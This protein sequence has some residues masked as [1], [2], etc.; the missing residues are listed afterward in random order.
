MRTVLFLFVAFSLLP[1]SVLAGA[2]LADPR[3]TDAY[4]V[5][6]DLEAHGSTALVNGYGGYVQVYEKSGTQWI[7]YCENFDGKG[8]SGRPN[9]KRERYKLL[10]FGTVDPTAY[11]CRDFTPAEIAVGQALIEMGNKKFFAVKSAAWTEKAGGE[12]LF[13]FAQKLPLLG[14]PTYKTLRIRATRASSALDYLVETVIP[15]ADVIPS[16]FYLFDVSGSALG[17]PNGID[18][19]TANPSEA[20]E[21]KIDIDGL[22]G[23]IQIRGDGK[24]KRNPAWPGKDSTVNVG[25]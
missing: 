2:P 21:K 5:I 20:T 3:N 19:L 9:P 25:S 16:H 10:P 17:F 8:T 15:R 1:F 13:Q 4:H 7:R 24:N 12:F 22:E 11:K 18:G 14:A 23:P 6:F